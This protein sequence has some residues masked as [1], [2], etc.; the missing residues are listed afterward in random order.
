MRVT[1]HGA[2]AHRNQLDSQ[3]SFQWANDYAEGFISDVAIPAEL[4]DS[5][6][7]SKIRRLALM[8]G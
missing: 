1:L 4:L 6:R 5:S 8:P 3:A 2:I 7:T